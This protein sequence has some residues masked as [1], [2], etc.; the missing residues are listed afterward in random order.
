MNAED[1][2][3]ER[4]WAENLGLRAVPLDSNE[5]GRFVMLNGSRGNFCLDVGP[6][7][8]NV[9]PR[10]D[11]WSSDVGH[12]V[13]ATSDEVSV[14][15][16]D[17]S[18]FSRRR[19]KADEVASNLSR[20]QLLLERDE[21]DRD[22]SVVSFM[23]RC[24]G[25]L[26]SAMENEQYVGESLRAFLVLLASCVDGTTRET[27]DLDEW[28]LP[29]E[30][31]EAAMRIDALQWRTLQDSMSTGR[32]DE[33][34][35]PRFRYVL[36]HAAGELFQQAHYL[37]QVMEGP[38]M[39]LGVAPPRPAK[40]LD[41]LPISSGVF[42]TPPHL[43]RTLAE[44]TCSGFDMGIAELTIFDPA[45]GSGEILREAIRELESLGYPGRVKII[46][47]DASPLAIDMA[48]FALRWEQRTSSLRALDISRI[49]CA[50]SLDLDMLWPQNVDAVVMNP[51]FVSYEG[52]AKDQKEHLR[53]L[54]GNK[55]GQR[56][57]LSSAFL[58]LA[59]RAAAEKR[60]RVGA[61]VPSSFLDAQSAMGTR[62]RLERDL[63]P[64]LIA[65]LGDLT[66]FRDAIVD[67]GMYVAGRTVSKKGKML[68]ASSSKAAISAALRTLRRFDGS[69]VAM[70]TYSIYPIQEPLNVE[71]WS[72]RPYQSVELIRQYQ[73]L[74][75][76]E[77]LFQV[78]QGVRTGENR[79]FV[80]NDEE[81]GALPR[82]ERKYFRDTIINKS[83]RRGRIVATVHMFYP[84][85]ECEIPD[86]ATL[87]QV[88]E[89]YYNEYL[90]PNKRKLEC[91]A[92]VP[93]NF[94]WH[95]TWP[96]TDKT[97]PKIITTAFGLRGAFAFDNVGT[98][99][100]INGFYWY[101]RTSVFHESIAFGYLAILNGELFNRLLGA[102]SRH[103]GG[104]QWDLQN[105]FVKPVPLPD[106][107]AREFPD[108]VLERLVRIGKC[109]YNG[110]DWPEETLWS[111]V[112]REA[113]DSAPPRKNP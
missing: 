41:K 37:A 47:W 98:K 60:G 52:L 23:T 86:E 39:L 67:A 106:I 20:F 80:L 108:L 43:A 110:G 112:V 17:Q 78:N 11:A 29:V 13:R 113:Y 96:R 27:L 26:R 54:L 50:N 9:D 83:I 45:C 87:S 25:S 77:N 72:P 28:N 51:P 31:R 73:H 74:T 69:P 55:V 4:Q 48:R 1:L 46:G 21:L 81:F 79:V 2:I 101:P 89:T 33:E 32:K 53:R 57:D 7:R 92:K 15:R 59:D 16:W 40:L 102:T 109:I 44:Q 34:L 49:E 30:A 8:D 12:Y 104:G 94:W 103:V 76:V 71:S 68:W 65:K 58:V 84:Y 42:Y 95:L 63:S 107:T 93:K 99:L 88:V 82:K 66:L 18:A 6:E 75:H 56:P 35:R 14:F 38:Q 24:F 61:I 5:P 19:F 22:G 3:D 111:D 85:G 64:I 97:V 100:V 70:D 91:R 36:R 90:L 105:R 62:E 10:S